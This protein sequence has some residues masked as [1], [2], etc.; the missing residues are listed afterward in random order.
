MPP[1]QI[2]ILIQSRVQKL[3][4]RGR[5][6][7]R[8]GPSASMWRLSGTVPSGLP[9]C[10]WLLLCRSRAVVC[11]HIVAL[12]KG[13]HFHSG[14]IY[15]CQSGPFHLRKNVC[16]HLALESDSWSTRPHCYLGAESRVNSQ[17]LRTI[18]LPLSIAFL[19]TLISCPLSFNLVWVKKQTKTLFKFPGSIQ[20]AFEKC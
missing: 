10:D 1:F 19:Q 15:L 17:W 16:A 8:G 6:C 12:C 5:P 11:Y 20:K 14:G 7:R 4:R 13:L 9:R 18:S 3:I 2:L